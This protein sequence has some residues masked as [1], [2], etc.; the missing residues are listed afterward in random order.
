M[1]ADEPTAADRPADP[2][3]RPGPDRDEDREIGAEGGDHPGGAPVPFAPDEDDDSSFGDTD[4]H[5]D[6]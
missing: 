6:A 3:E 5:S 2:D 1:H 4:Q